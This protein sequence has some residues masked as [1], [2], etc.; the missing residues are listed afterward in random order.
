MTLGLTVRN[1]EVITHPFKVIRRETE[2][3]QDELVTGS[4]LKSNCLGI[5]VNS[6]SI[7]I[8]LTRRVLA[9]TKCLSPPFRGTGVHGGWDKLKMLKALNQRSQWRDTFDFPLSS[10]EW[11]LTR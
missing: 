2:T 1:T 4:E 5:Q 8:A 6:L 9:K 11:Y 3:T 7:T 10:M